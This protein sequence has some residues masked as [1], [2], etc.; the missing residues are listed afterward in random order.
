ML[1]GCLFVSRSAFV[2]WKSF[3]P[4]A[5]SSSRET[6]SRML[7]D[8]LLAFIR[9]DLTP[10]REEKQSLCH[11]QNRREEQCHLP[12]GTL[13]IQA[14]TVPFSYRRVRSLMMQ[15]ARELPP[16]LQREDDRLA[17]RMS[18]TLLERRPTRRTAI[19]CRIWL[20]MENMRGECRY[21]KQ[22]ERRGWYSLD[23]S[24]CLEIS[25]CATRTREQFLLFYYY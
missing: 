12:S 3:W 11:I 21:P 16:K 1:Y 25:G 13:L 10:H 4:N 22:Q 23:I 19:V 5:E 17:G 14:K 9:K 20:V 24:L 7:P 15:C 18:E 8:K 2:T 6:S